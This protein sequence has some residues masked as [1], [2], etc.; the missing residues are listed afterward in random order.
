MR[1]SGSSGRPARPESSSPEKIKQRN[2]QKLEQEKQAVEEES[3]GGVIA[4]ESGDDFQEGK[5]G[6]V[7]VNEEPEINNDALNQQL[8]R[9]PEE[10]DDEEEQ[11]ID[12]E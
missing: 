7:R 12:E 8:Q 10:E 3:D 6:S 2:Q 1:K 9:A 11:E 5:Q 4:Q